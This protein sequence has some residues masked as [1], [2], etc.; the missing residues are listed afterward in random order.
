MLDWIKRIKSSPPDL[1]VVETEDQNPASEQRLERLLV[2]LHTDRGPG[3]DSGPEANTNG[4][5]TNEPGS[6]VVAEIGAPAEAGPP[7]LSV[8]A[9]ASG[10]A[11]ESSP[12]V[13][14]GVDA[15]V[16]AEIAAA[17]ERAAAGESSAPGNG[18]AAAETAPALDPDLEAEI[19]AAVD[20]LDLEA[21]AVPAP[22]STVGEET[23]A[24]EDEP[25][26]DADSGPILGATLSP[27]PEKAMAVEGGLL[28]TRRTAAPA[29]S[30]EMKIIAVCSQKGG[31]GKT[32]VA[33][34]LAVQAG[35]SGNGPAVLIDTD[36]QGSLAEWWRAR[37]DDSPALARVKLEELEDNLTELRGYGTAVTIIDTPPALTHSIE[38]VMAIADLIVIP[39]RPSPHDL[40]AVGGTVEM[41]RRAG[42][43]FVFVLNGA[44]QR[45]NITVQAVA[46]LSE[47]GRVAPVILYQRTEF[48]ASMIDGRTVIEAAPSGK[49]A[50]E[51]SALWKF[52]YAQI[53][54]RAAA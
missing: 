20:S 40:R 37:K 36:P 44:A 39:A 35:L 9:E 24:T 26:A 18:S 31:S 45:A 6:N 22:D 14:T 47:H 11:V 51:V 1:K 43:P 3:P 38:Q 19:K 2:R 4:A 30:A 21:S 33:G 50:Q 34:H 16:I 13:D 28:T 15:G 25:E 10:A 42:K 48:A 49:S 8:V 7:A 54:M 27:A 5:N 41:C 52:V 17:V 53:N 29:A 32:T 12:R 23:L 46:A